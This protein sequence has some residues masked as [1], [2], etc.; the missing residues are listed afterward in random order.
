MKSVGPSDG[1]M[2]GNESKDKKP[3]FLGCE[4][5]IAQ[6]LITA[7]KDAHILRCSASIGISRRCATEPPN[8]MIDP[9]ATENFVFVTLVGNF[10]TLCQE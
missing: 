6:S 10:H 5:E 4:N 7:N 1:V 9:G 2:N 8:T 3:S